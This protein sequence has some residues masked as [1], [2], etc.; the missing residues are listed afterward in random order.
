MKRQKRNI[1]IGLLIV[2]IAI[3]A[4]NILRVNK[5]D[6]FPKI[7]EATVNYEIEKQEDD[8]KG[9]LVQII[10]NEKKVL[11]E[12]IFDFLENPINIENLNVYSFFNNTIILK[13]TGEQVAGGE[14]NV[15]FIISLDTLEA[16][17]LQNRPNGHI[18]ATKPLSPSG[19][20]LLYPDYMPSE[21]YEFR[22]ILVYDLLKDTEI[23]VAKLPQEESLTEGFKVVSYLPLI[24]AMFAI[25]WEDDN[26]IRYNAFSTEQELIKP[27]DLGN[28]GSHGPLRTLLETRFLDIQ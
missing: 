15:L 21:E 3:L 11:I 9:S 2:F 24:E 4:L 6:E 19:R 20:Y 26:T 13:G 10:D 5:R 7:T 25:E 17:R 27:S 12:D 18:V 14:L 16:K 8:K 23:L 1:V 28:V 22:N